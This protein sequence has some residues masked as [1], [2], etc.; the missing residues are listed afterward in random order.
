M[1]LVFNV[2]NNH[3]LLQIENPLIEKEAFKRAESSHTEEA[4]LEL[5]CFRCRLYQVL[6]DNTVGLDTIVFLEL[7]KVGAS[8]SQL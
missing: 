6:V 8:F 2:E 3:I 5:S 1:Y 7:V 4:N